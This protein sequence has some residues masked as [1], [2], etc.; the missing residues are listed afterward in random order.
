MTIP[1][2]ANAANNLL[3]SFIEIGLGG[4]IILAARKWGIR[5]AYVMIAIGLAGTLTCIG[6]ILLSG[7]SVAGITIIQIVVVTVMLGIWAH[8]LRGTLKGAKGTV[9]SATT[10]VNPQETVGS[11]GI[12]VFAPRGVTPARGVC[13]IRDV[14]IVTVPAS[15]GTKHFVFQCTTI[16]HGFDSKA[17]ASPAKLRV[18]GSGDRD[19]IVVLE[20]RGRAHATER[21]FAPGITV[22]NAP[23]Y[24]A[25]L[26]QL[27]KAIRREMGE[28]FEVTMPATK[29]MYCYVEIRLPFDGADLELHR[30][31]G[32]K[33]DFELD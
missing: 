11:G 18:T 4:L 25:Q 27:A 23:I 17:V 30:A 2:T 29:P 3:P 14:S 24:L 32:V 13:T 10:D 1:D 8:L 6:M 31:S 12:V 26:H 22:Y 28:N 7:K 9:A 15:D 20:T 33:M 21:S 19:D 16:L 5:E